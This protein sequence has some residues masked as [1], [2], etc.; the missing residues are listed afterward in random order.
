LL[1]RDHQ[2]GIGAAVTQRGQQPCRD[3]DQLVPPR[4]IEERREL[5]QRPSP[6]RHR[7]RQ[8]AGRPAEAHRR[9]RHDPPAVGADLGRPPGLIREIEVDA[10]VVLG[11]AD[12]DHPLGAL[13]LRPRLEQIKR[14]V[15][16]RCARDVA[17]RLVITPSQP[18]SKPLAS[19]TTPSSDCNSE[20]LPVT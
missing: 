6:L 14:C 13:E 10:P 1:A 5:F 11:D 2:E 7:Q 12:M 3:Q 20:R 18:E 15:E 16:R 4:Q 9:L 17:G 8:Q 19:V